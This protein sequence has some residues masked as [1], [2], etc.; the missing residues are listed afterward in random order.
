MNDNLTLHGAGFR[1]LDSLREVEAVQI[2]LDDKGAQSL[3]ALSNLIQLNIINS[4]QNCK[5]LPFE[6]L[7]TT[8]K[9]TDLQVSGMQA[10]DLAGIGKIKSLRMLVIQQYKNDSLQ[11]KDLQALK[12]LKNLNSLLLCDFHN[13]TGG[14]V[15]KLML[16]LPDCKVTV[17]KDPNP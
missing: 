12:N 9:I 4:T 1:T 6:L 3:F 14:G 7:S 2:S 11:D 16:L 5:N 17:A 13:I 8:A 10:S 15:S